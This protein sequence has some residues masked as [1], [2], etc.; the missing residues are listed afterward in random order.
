ML[1][2][3]KIKEKERKKK[4]IAK[5]SREVLPM[6]AMVP[7]HTNTFREGGGSS[8]NTLEINTEQQQQHARG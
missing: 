2:E 1:E 6:T 5:G 3:E 8:I 4:R 7:R